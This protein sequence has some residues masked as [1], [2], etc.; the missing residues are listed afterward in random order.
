VGSPKTGLEERFRYRI[1]VNAHRINQGEMPE[2]PTRGDNSDFFF[3]EV[4]D[5][6]DGAAKAVEIR[7]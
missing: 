4:T 1:V 6:E 7:P 5:S 3:I 2:W